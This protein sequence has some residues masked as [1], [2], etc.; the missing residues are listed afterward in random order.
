MKGFVAL[1]RKS[2]TLARLLMPSLK[3]LL[4]PSEYIMVWMTEQARGKK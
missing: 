1:V 3:I 2:F 4:Y